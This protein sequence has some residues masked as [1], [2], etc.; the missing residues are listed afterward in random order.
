MKGDKS[1]SFPY[2]GYVNPGVQCRD[3]ASCTCRNQETE[4]VSN[5]VPVGHPWAHTLGQAKKYRCHEA[6]R[7]SARGERAE[8]KTMAMAKPSMVDA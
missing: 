3:L 4:D 6:G 7:G 1:S 8:A 5:A 2:T